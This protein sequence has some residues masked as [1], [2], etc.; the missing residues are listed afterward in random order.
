M[1]DLVYV[2]MDSQFGNWEF[3]QDILWI[4]VYDRKEEKCDGEN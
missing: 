3:I 4:N 2:G 1:E